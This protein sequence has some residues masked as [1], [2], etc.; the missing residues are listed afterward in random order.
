MLR[1]PELDPKDP[2]EISY[3]SL[4]EAVG[5]LYATCARLGGSAYCGVIGCALYD[6]NLTVVHI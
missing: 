5:Q 6:K 3:V 4:G 2:L 1:P